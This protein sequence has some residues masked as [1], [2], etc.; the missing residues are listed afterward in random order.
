MRF[1]PSNWVSVLELADM[2][3]M[4]K[5]RSNALNALEADR[6]SMKP[7]RKIALGMRWNRRPWVEEG[8]REIAVQAESMSNVQIDT[9]GSLAAS[10]LAKVREQ[11]SSW[12]GFA[13]LSKKNV[14]E[15]WEADNGH[16]VVAIAAELTPDWKPPR[17]VAVL[18]VA[19]KEWVYRVSSVLSP[20]LFF[21]SSCGL[22]YNGGISCHEI[23]CT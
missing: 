8:A 17:A 11:I 13:H 19:Y 16:W 5:L 2:W 1:K 23:L 20:F 22:C 18:P 12:C 4:A 10:K 7:E 3:Q 14:R 21:L 6:E 9:V 15:K